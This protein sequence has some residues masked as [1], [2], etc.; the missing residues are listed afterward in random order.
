MKE[1]YKV[2]K[3]IGSGLFIKVYNF[4]SLNEVGHYRYSTENRG[5]SN[6]LVGIWKQKKI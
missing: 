3:T 5:R 1:G 4:T 6:Y 2:N